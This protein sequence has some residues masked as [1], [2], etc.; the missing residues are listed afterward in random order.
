MENRRQ[1]L[2][3]AGLL[4]AAAVPSRTIVVENAE[5][6]LV[7]TPRGTAQSLIHKATGQ[8]C[9]TPGLNL[10]MFSVTQYRPYDNELQLAY[11]AKPKAFPAENI[12]REEDRLIVDFSLVGYQAAIQLRI[13]DAY[14][15]FTLERLTYHGYTSLRTKRKTAIDESIFLQLPVRN[16]KN[17]GE[18]LNVMWDDAVAV[19]LLGTDPYARVD[20]TACG[21]YRLMQI[22]TVD[23]VKTEGVG[24]AL[25]VTETR[26]LL[27]RVAKV[28]EDYHLPRGVESRRR[29]E[30]R[31]S[32]YELSKATLGNIDRH[33]RFARLAGLQTMDVHYRAFSKTCGHFPWRPEYPNGIKDVQRLVE[34]IAQAGITPGIHIHYNK[35]DKEDAYV[36]PHPDPRLSLAASF[37]LREA[38]DSSSKTITVEENPRQCTLDDGRRILKIQDELISYERYTTDPPYRFVGCERGALGSQASS[39]PVESRVGL[40]DVDTWPTFVRLSQNTDIQEEVAQRLA[41]IYRGAGFK[42]VY[43]DGAEDVPGPEYWYT[44]SRAQWLVYKDL[45]PPPLFSEGACKSHFSWHILTRGN[46]FDVFKPEVAKAAVR[47]YPAAEAPRAAKDFTSINFGWIGYW[48]PT[49]ETIGTQP[50]IIEYVASRAAGWD[51][52]I[53]LV[54]DLEQLEAHPRTPDNLEVIRRWEVARAKNLLS[55]AQKIALRNLDQEHTL[56]IDEQGGFELTP[57]LE[58]E[59]VGGG[60][61]PARAFIFSRKEKTYVVF[62]HM[63]GKASMDVPLEGGAVRLMAELGKSLDLQKVIGGIRI[64]LEGRLYLECGGVPRETIVRAFQNAKILV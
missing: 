18:W 60:K 3:E 41:G 15:G 16:R 38:L 63:S 61:T 27:D 8:E 11:P 13:T 28:E 1:F 26:K 64:P 50:D 17:F 25:I 57:Y 7:I 22:G 62:W 59:N 31:Q 32:Y 44:V 45:N 23:S 9:L 39:Y 47:A 34:R 33:I 2:K 48:A 42:F 30:Y 37:T 51:C 46:A 52:P 43:F 19:N 10:P 12:R 35:A 24:G 49:H 36:T 4:A 40:L 54:G 56:L 6:R 53:S 5:M 29:K 14:I 20:A 55:P 21:N 58:I